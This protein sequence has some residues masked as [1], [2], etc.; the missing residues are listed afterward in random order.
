M[1]MDR[2]VLK[3]APLH[4]ILLWVEIEGVLR[5]YSG[6]QVVVLFLFLPGVAKVVPE[7]VS[8]VL[9]A[10]VAVQPFKKER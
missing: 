1:A 3:S 2:M 9:K 10:F 6:D 5:R 4:C 7:N 8:A